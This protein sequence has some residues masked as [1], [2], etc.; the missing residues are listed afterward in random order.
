MADIIVDIL[1]SIVVYVLLLPV[2]FIISTP[3][4]LV[5]SFF[6]E[7]SYDENLKY[8]YGKIWKFYLKIVAYF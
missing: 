6:G 8:Y 4:I 5:V 2:T 3:A 1:I 7:K